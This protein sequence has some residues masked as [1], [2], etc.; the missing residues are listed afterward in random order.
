MRP[1]LS[2]PPRAL[3]ISLSGRGHAGAEGQSAARRSP[4]WASFFTRDP[5]LTYSASLV[6]IAALVLLLERGPAALVPLSVLSI[7]LVGAQVVLGQIPARR[8]PMTA[9]GWSFLRL[10]L[11]LLFVAG[12]VELSGGAAG[13]MVALFIPVVVAA[14]ALGTLQ[15]VL[16]GTIA[17][18]IYLA[19]EITRLGS[20][21]DLALRGITLAGVSVLVAI[22]I[23]RLVVT[24][25][26][27]TRE[28]RSAIVA[29]RRRSRQIAGLEAVSRLLV[30]G[31]PSNE[32]LDRAL[33][34]LVERFGYSYVSIYI[35]DGDVLVLGAQRG[36]D[37]PIQSFD[38]SAG[39]VGRVMRSRELAYVP[40]VTQDADYIAVFDEVR[41]EICAPLV[42]DD[43]LLGILN[44]ESKDRLDRTDRDLV[45]T[46]AGRVATVVALGRDRQALTQRGDIFRRLHEFTQ[47]VSGT[48]ALEPLGA[49]LVEAARRV[50]PSDHIA[51][52]V[53]DQKSGRYRVRAITDAETSELG[54]EVRP[55]EGLAGR[56]IRDRTIVFDGAFTNEQFPASYRETA[57]PVTLLGAGVPLVRDGAVVGALSIMRRDL[58]DQ[59]SALE[60][61][62]MELL[63]GHAALVL[64]NAFLHAEVEQLAIRDPLTG[65]Y[66]R[67]YFDE[68]LERVIAGWNRAT[69]SGRKSVAAIVFDLDLFG[70]FN[71]QHGHQVGDLV[72]RKFAGI[73]RERF[74]A[75]DLVARLGGEEFIV[76]LEGASRSDAERLAEEVREAL[77]RQELRNE[78]GARL[79][80]TV[81]AGCA[82]LDEGQATGELLLRTADVAL[83]MAK[84]AG[85]DRVVAA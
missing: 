45:A 83:F 10:I 48:L 8:R 22:G 78:D 79:T 42:V 68:A 58:A 62:A 59:F 53:L 34:V 44:V 7:C 77:R 4:R 32:V 16:I 27:R 49:S 11:A 2:R 9:L 84:R 12:L 46:L 60:R 51:L 35:A 40:A 65:L 26:H 63:A 15:A 39:I 70:D 13:P 72:L 5:Y 61:E 6:P 36:Y 30:A 31:G 52:T 1:A 18:I 14:A 47:A 55:G 69:G 66:N 19:P 21:A 24:V 50:V 64:A 54:G 67:R 25:E 41:S 37:H 56:A 82:Q 38:G 23:R 81:S 20:S 3:R 43:Q 29:E 85:R 57:E 73:L 33:G 75:T 74:R 71:K 28:M 80:V 76:V 17:S